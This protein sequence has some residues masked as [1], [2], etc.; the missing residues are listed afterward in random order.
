M[1][2][3]QL[4][5]LMAEQAP[6]DMAAPPRLSGAPVHFVGQPPTLNATIEFVNDSSDKNRVRYLEL[7]DFEIATPAQVRVMGRLQAKECRSLNAAVNIQAATPAGEYA[8]VVRCGEEQ[9]AAVLHVLERFDLEVL[10]QELELHASGG[11]KV[12]ATVVAVNRGNVDFIVPKVTKIHLEEDDWV[13]RSAV[14]ALKN[15]RPAGFDDFMNKLTG[16]VF[17]RQVSA[18][19][20]NVRTG[21]YRI[22]AGQTGTLEL[23]IQLPPLGQHSSFHGPMKLNRLEI[24]VAVDTWVS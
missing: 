9:Q 14:A 2:E 7:A 24:P 12:T 8:G 22:A 10:P 19:T 1:T 23:E 21:N 6:P 16:E 3:D 15:A 17:A 13:G 20:V 11:D 5:D 18:A 4:N